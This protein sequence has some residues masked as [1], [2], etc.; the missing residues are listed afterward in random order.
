MKKVYLFKYGLTVLFLI[1][2]FSVFA[3]KSVFKGK[4]V[5]ELNQPLPG[6][7]IHAKETDQSVITDANGLFS[8]VGNNQAVLTVQVSFVGYD[9]A[10]VTIK[11]N[12]T[13][14][15]KLVPNSKS[16]TEV[17]V[18]GY[19][20]IRKT[21]VTGA[22]ANIGAKD[23]NPGSVTNPLQQIVGK[24]PG[25][26]I[27]EVG[28]EPGVAPTIRIR[29]ITSLSGGNDPLVVVDGV[30][31]NMD[32]LNQVPP[33]EILSFDILKDASATAI[34]GSRGATGVV[35][36]TTKKG[37][38]GKTN[39]EY[40][41]NTSLDVIPKH[42]DM[43]TAAGWTKQAEAQG[44]DV[45]AN[46]GSNT[47]W[48]NLLTQNGVT[49]NHTLAFGSGANGFNY[50]ASITA[51]NQTGVVINSSYKKYIGRIVATQ[52]ALDDKLTLTMNINSGVND[53]VYSPIGVGN[54]AFKS[55]AISQA[56]LARPTDPVY[57][58]DGSY[59]IDPNV[60]QYSN[61][62]AIAKEVKNDVNQNQFM[63]SL[64]ADLD[65][66]K[67]LSAGWFGSW[68]KI[69]QNTGYYAPVSSTITDAITY[70]GQ[71]HINNDHTD[72]KLMDINLSY[73]R[74]FGLSHLDATAVY[75]YQIQTYFGS[76]A[77]ARGFVNDLATYN[78]LQSGTLASAQNGD[79]TSYKN[80]RKL[81][82]YLGRVNY[83]YNNRYY[84][85]ASFRAD[86]SSVFGANHQF[87]YFPSAS[88]AWRLD[89]EDII[90]ALPVISTLKLRG[91]YGSTGNQQGL[92]V[93]GSLSLVAP[94]LNNPVV[95]FNGELRTAYD[96]FQN[97]NPDLRW[98]T[99]TETN[100][101]LDFGLFKD[102]L[103]GTVD[104]YTSKT[105]NLL[106]RYNV[107]ISGPFKV[108]SI[109]AN[110]GTLQNK[111]LEL[112]LSYAVI[113]NDKV[114]LTLAG[115]GSLM[116]NKVLQLSGV[117][118]G[119]QASTNYQPWGTNA[120]LVEGQPIGTYLIY[121]HT[122]VDAN[123]VE[124]FAGQKADGSFDATAQSKI[125]YNA[126]QSLPKY[127]YAFTPSFT[128]KNFD[129][130]MVWRG[131]GG[132][133]IF[134]GIRSNFSMLDNLGKQNLLQ[135]AIATG[136]HSSAVQSD[137]WLESGSYL[138]FQNLSLGYR[139][140]LTNVKYIS[141]LRLS[142]TGQNLALITKYKGTDPEVDASGG[143][144]SGGD[145][146]VYPRTRT[147]SAGLNVVLK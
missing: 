28:S 93:Q 33:S 45:S 142:L 47:D 4:V 60:F 125:R 50:R 120:W 76:H 138:R 43:L 134:N 101:G 97:A 40:S 124:T 80:D 51:I 130:S 78:S 11:A 140:N 95:Y 30:Q 123:G 94:S 100:L 83:S 98:E 21:D 96:Y 57:N 2:A 135:S 141:A 59:Y 104:A 74:N 139:F 37:V 24:A 77:A 64:R 18:V 103:T 22:V 87:G 23:L 84:L 36:V 122:G 86:G 25:V 32:L 68:R 89:Q 49:Q 118:E 90:K 35:I 1:C 109:L 34:Y 116:Q 75:E 132:N 12:E 5:D 107:N 119:V 10:S 54:V 65:I 17:V 38:A 29:G 137:E 46:H 102:R 56:Y 58:T 8:L 53:A 108:N 20:T 31:G 52:K 85:T 113:R 16:L 110:A 114:T 106:Y 81:V 44:V 13:A 112:S 105:K 146:G 27:S 7:T 66:Y 145:Y 14:A 88:A 73:K 15:I 67:G 41:E 82:S 128:Y 131:S 71:A 69:D 147:F 55:N 6:A 42:L 91:G 19:G 62:Y 70:N 144:S 26:V 111:G 143:N 61:P 136:I 79:V 115:N 127:T 48:Y 121:K 63:G 126:G 133:K 92:P 129:A 99:R 3:Q 39:I 72:E 117:I 9:V